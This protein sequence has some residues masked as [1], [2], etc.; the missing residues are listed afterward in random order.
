VERSP[1]LTCVSFWTTLRR[2]TTRIARREA[3]IHG[4]KH[5]TLLAVESPKAYLQ[6]FSRSFQRRTSRSHSRWSTLKR[7]AIFG[8]RW[9]KANL[10]KKGPRF[11][12]VERESKFRS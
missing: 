7:T 1:S 5:F 9:S 3:L 4:A 12:A 10:D 2:S 8:P 11:Q 6:P